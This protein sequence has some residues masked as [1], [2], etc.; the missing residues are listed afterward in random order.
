MAPFGYAFILGGILLLRQVLVGRAMDTPGDTRDLALALLSGDMTEVGSVLARRG[1]ETADATGGGSPVASANTP[2]VAEVMRLG[3]AAKGYR[4]GATGPDYYDC[5]SLIWRAMRNLDIYTGPRFTTHTFAAVAAAKGW[6][7]VDLPEAGDV[8]LWRT[9]KHGH[10]GVATG[11][12]GMYSARNEEKG[13]NMS[14]IAGDSSVL[15]SPSFYRI[16]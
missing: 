8:V 1:S 10:M 16:S 11:G 4:L 9:V 3:E 5:S 15:G 6:A 12:D 14:S 13:I 2:L 7:K